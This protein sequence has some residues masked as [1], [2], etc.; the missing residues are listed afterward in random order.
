MVISGRAG[1]TPHQQRRYARFQRVVR[2]FNNQP[3]ASVI[4]SDRATPAA[5][6]WLPDA[7]PSGWALDAHADAVGV[8][9]GSI[10]EV[11]PAVVRGFNISDRLQPNAR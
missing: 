10:F 3:L 1:D 8:A 4:S 11:S 6:Q 7:S 9:G 2:N 5:T